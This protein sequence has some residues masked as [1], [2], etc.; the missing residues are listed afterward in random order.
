MVALSEAQR[1]QRIS[2]RRG[3]SAA[4]LPDE[5]LESHY[6]G[7]GERNHDGDH[8]APGLLQG[9]RNELGED[10]PDHGSSRKPQPD[11]QQGQVRQSSKL[12]ALNSARMCEDLSGEVRR[13]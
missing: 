2:S 8:V 10:H 6:R 1:P 11:R 13:I 4:Y 5:E 9:V 12:S 3:K 7:D